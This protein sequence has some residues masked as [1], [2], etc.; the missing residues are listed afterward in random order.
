[1]C[2]QDEYNVWEEGVM[3]TFV[4]LVRIIYWKLEDEH[5]TIIRRNKEWFAWFLPHLIHVQDIIEKEKNGDWTTRL[6]KRK[7]TK[8][9]PSLLVIRAP[10]E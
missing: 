9:A 4:N 3:M 1:M 5:C 2:T 8:D 10:A 6:P 7:A